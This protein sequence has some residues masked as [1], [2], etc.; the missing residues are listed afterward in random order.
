M[1]AIFE[2]A[3][4]AQHSTR[5]QLPHHEGMTLAQLTEI[6]EEVGI[7]PELVADAA[8]ALDHGAQAT[9]RRLLGLPIGVGRTVDLHRE[10]TDEEWEHLVVDLRE[11]FDAKGR[12]SSQGSL[13]QWTNG[14]LQAL[15]EPTPDGHRL[16][17]RTTYG[18]ARV[19]MTMGAAFVG[20]T[21]AMMAAAA[22][23]GD[24]G[25]A[26]SS[27]GTIFLVGVTFFVVGAAPLPR[28]ARTRAKQMEHV[29][30]KLG[31]GAADRI[32]GSSDSGIE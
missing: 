16:R 30:R 1:A 11:T 26:I 24:L 23:A 22:I 10:L 19:F 31:A 18:N 6:G 3:T 2:R 32:E 15:L 17:L 5:R 14:N 12:V 28:W 7:A 21:G 8:Q 27:V 13:K 29:A 9:T 25:Q 20:F 4:E